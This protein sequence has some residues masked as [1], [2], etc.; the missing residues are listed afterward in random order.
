MDTTENMIGEQRFGFFAHAQ[1]DLNAHLR[2]FEGSFSLDA[3]LIYLSLHDN[4]IFLIS[5]VFYSENC[6]AFYL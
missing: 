3:A 1:Y 5:P 2:M 4:E 6:M